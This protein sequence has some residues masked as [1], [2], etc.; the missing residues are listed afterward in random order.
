ME[1]LNFRHLYAFWAVC[2]HGGFAKAAARVHVSQST[3]SEQVSQLEDYL[4]EKLFVRSTRSVRVTERGAALLKVADDIFSLSARVN[5]VFRD[6]HDSAAAAK[7][8]IGMVGGVSRNFVF[9]LILATL[10][11]GGQASVEV[12]DGSFDE[13]N[14]L[15]KTFELDL[16]FSLEQPRQ[17][18]LLTLASK[19]VARS[20]LC[21]AGS[22]ELVQR[23]K[24][25][26]KN[27]LKVELYTFRHPLDGREPAAFVA[28]KY[29]LEPHVPVTTDDISLLRFLANAGRGLALVPEIG[30]QEDLASGALSRIRLDEAPSAEFYATFLRH[31]AHREQIDDFLG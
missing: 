4:E 20:A 13:L 21:L 25:R 11:E 7:I 29:H 22:P 12:V 6:K 1:W 16:I 31:G 9:G 17:K 8:R 10:E 18:D 27:P 28:E 30:I 15:L 19:R 2:H 3:I 14:Q 5:L 26:R 24:R 23:V